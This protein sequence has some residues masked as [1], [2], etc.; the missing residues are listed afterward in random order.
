[1]QGFVTTQLAQYVF[2]GEAAWYTNSYF[3]PTGTEID[4]VFPTHE[5]AMVFGL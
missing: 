3:L 1:M 4:D 5:P 2:L